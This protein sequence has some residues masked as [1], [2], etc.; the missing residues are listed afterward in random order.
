M[1]SRGRKYMKAK[2]YGIAYGLT[3]VSILMISCTSLMIPTKASTYYEK[4]DTGWKGENAFFG[5]PYI[6]GDGD[7]FNVHFSDDLA[8]EGTGGAAGGAGQNME[9]KEINSPSG[10]RRYVEDRDY[11]IIEETEGDDF[12]LSNY[13]W[14]IDKHHW[15]RKE[16]GHKT[17]NTYYYTDYF[18]FE[19][20]YDKYIYGI[21][22]DHGE[23]E[24]MYKA[25]FTYTSS[26]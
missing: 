19:G 18:V 13:E 4:G 11:Q 3:I 2:I 23:F 24:Y 25:S 26:I 6:T 1:K 14:E 22:V 17:S 21:G 9:M 8:Y 12:Y 7:D 20:H 15:Q 5:D 10:T 16:T